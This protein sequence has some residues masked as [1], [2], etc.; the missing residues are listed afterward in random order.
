MR[1]GTLIRYGLTSF[2]VLLMIVMTACSNS[3]SDANGDNGQNNGKGVT[4]FQLLVFDMHVGGLTPNED[5]R[6]FNIWPAFTQGL[7][8]QKGVA[9]ELVGGGPRD[10]GYFK[11]VD[12]KMASGDVPD[13]LYLN[14]AQSDLYGSQGGLLDLAPLIKKYAPNVQQYIDDHA[15]YKSYVTN[16]K[17]KI[18]SIPWERATE[19]PNYSWVYRKDWFDQLNLQPPTTPEQLTEVLRALKKANPG[20]QRNFYP[21]TYEGSNTGFTSLSHVFGGQFRMSPDG[22]ISGVYAPDGA[23]ND[24]FSPGFKNMIEYLN[25]LY[26]EELLDP[27]AANLAINEETM[28]QK[29]ITGNSAI[30]FRTPNRAREWQNA[31]RQTNPD[32]TFDV[33][34]PLPNLDDGEYFL[35]STPHFYDPFNIAVS[36]KSDHAEAV[37]KFLDYIF[38]P[39]TQTLIHWGIEGKSYKIVNG[40]KEMLI[41][42]A[43]TLKVDANGKS[44]ANSNKDFFSLPGPSDSDVKIALQDE[45][46][47]DQYKVLQPYVKDIPYLQLNLDQ[48][49]ELTE[50]QAKYADKANKWLSDFITGKRPISDWD[51]FLKDMEDLGYKRAGEI[52][53]EAYKKY[54]QALHE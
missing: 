33:F 23:G 34:K 22:K 25:Q 45:S 21:L 26:K 30:T 36:A 48:Q 3:S 51:A 4:T 53:S 47:R 52:W 28:T 18:F 1:N 17:G 29:M 41:G 27:E 49:K 5:I 40:E 35:P 37:V 19:V 15:W 38:K 9:V 31:G 2:I 46:M 32:Y 16:D 14:R 8:E 24:F 44:W 6:N 13:A 42:F 12:L 10:N 43:D 11:N 54:L 50:L 7:Q 20:N 39:E